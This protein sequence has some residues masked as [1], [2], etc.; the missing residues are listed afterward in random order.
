MDKIKEK[1]ADKRLFGMLLATLGVSFVFPEYIAPIFVFFLYIPFLI[2]FK[3]TGRNAL[4]GQLGKVFMA[5]FC[6]MII[7]AIWSGTHILSALMGLL[8]M[9]CFLGF[10]EVGNI[11]NTKEKLKDAITA[12]NVSS[13]IIGLIGVLQFVTYNLCRHTDWFS[14]RVSNPLYYELDNTIYKM[15][16]FDIINSVFPS[17]AAS[18]FSNPLILATF[19]VITIPFCAFGS[20]YFKK[21]KHRKISRACFIFAICGLICT[22]SRGACIAIAL[23]IATLLVSN[24]KMFK[25][26]LPFILAIAISVPIILVV[27]YN[28]SPSGDFLSSTNQRFGIWKVCANVIKEHWFV[29]L[30][31]G[32]ENLHQI[33]LEALQKDRAHA[34]NLFLQVLVEGGIVGGAIVATIIAIII[35]NI[36]TIFKCKDGAYRPYAVLY[37]ASLIGFITISLFEYT[38]QSPKEMMAFFILLGF[39][40]ATL[41]MAQNNN[42]LIEADKED[43]HDLSKEDYITDKEE[44]KA[45]TTK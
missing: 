36:F 30:G 19:L 44:K 23:S 13:G 10:L 6:Y 11:V 7:S 32:T 38:L 4:M 15:F 8:W 26:L 5:Y 29:G 37:T 2:H 40:E 42:Q 3:K 35:R 24:K 18:T 39:I 14:F 28:N 34:H 20:V 33:L 41:R 27:R 1:S 16:S 21:S 43:Y 12:I 22:E 9:G 45:L 17:R 25:K 31:A